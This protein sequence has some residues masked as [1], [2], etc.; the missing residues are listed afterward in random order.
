[1]IAV[2]GGQ[3]RETGNAEISRQDITASLVPSRFRG[4]P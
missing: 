4:R 1:V 2:I 3:R